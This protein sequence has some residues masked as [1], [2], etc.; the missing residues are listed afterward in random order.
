MLSN[1]RNEILPNV[2]ENYR[3]LNEGE[4]PA[5]SRVNYFCCGL[6]TLVHMTEVSQKSLYETKKEYF[7]GGIQILNKSFEKS[8][9]PGT[10]RLS[11]LPAR[12][13]LDVVIKRMADTVELLL[14][15]HVFKG[16]WNKRLPSTTSQRE[17]ALIFYSQIRVTYT[18]GSRNL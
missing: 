8:C 11:T 15:F 17:T 13:L 3:N 5:H 4:K 7:E 18:F 16:P 1:Y 12:H 10:V 2:I 9:Q 14:L 6:H